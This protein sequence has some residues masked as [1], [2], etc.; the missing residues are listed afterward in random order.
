M[1]GFNF[2]NFAIQSLLVTNNDVVDATLSQIRLDWDYAE[3]YGNANGYPNLSVDWFTWNFGYFHLGIEGDGVK[4]YGSPTNW[5]GALPFNSGST[6]IWAVDFDDVWGGSSPM[7]GVLSSDFGV[8]LDFTNGCQLRRDAVARPVSTWTP[9]PTPTTTW[10]P[11]PI[12]PTNTSPP[13]TVTFT[14]TATSLPTFTHT[15]TYTPTITPT[16]SDTP[17]AS[18]TP[19]PTNTTVFT[20]TPIPSDTPYYTPTNT[21]SPTLPPTPIP[22]DTPFPT[23]NPDG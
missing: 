9:T 19:I 12:P 13:P 11:S 22:T 8:I 15:H 3:Q 14:A 18:I 17:T 6:Y 7:T 16:P 21:S 5:S 4:D 23:I 20:D 10:T 2:S 1:T